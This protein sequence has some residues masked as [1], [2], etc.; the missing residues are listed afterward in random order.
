MGN[1]NEIREWQQKGLASDTISINN[2]ILVCNAIAYPL[3]IDPQI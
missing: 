3:I 2:A 1:A